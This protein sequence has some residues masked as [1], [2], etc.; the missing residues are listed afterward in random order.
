MLNP[1]KDIF[2]NIKVFS[3]GDGNTAVGIDIGSSA[4][5]V[6][7]I[8]KK[9]GKAMLETYGA[10][11]LGPYAELP[12]GE[13]TNLPVEKLAQ[14]VKEVLKQSGAV[15]DKA[16]IALPVQASLIF[17]IELPT[18]VKESEIAAIVPNEARRYIPV[19]ITEVSLD[20][21]MLPKK[22][23]SFE[24]MSSGE[25]IQ[26][27]AEKN[28]VL[29]VATQNDV[30]AKYRSIASQAGIK[31][32]FFEIEIFSSIRS[33]FE[34]ELS[35]VLLM[36]FGASRTKLS[37]V[38][39]GMVK[40]YHTIDRG[41][42]DITRSIATSLGVSFAQAEKMKKETGLFASSD[43]N[44]IG[45]IV[46]THIDYIFSEANNV[47]LGHEKKY[48]K[49]ITKVILSG[50]GSLLKGLEQAASSNFRAE[51]EFGRPFSKVG[52]PEFLNK[53]LAAT[54]P[55]FA[56]ALGIALRKLQ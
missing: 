50:G 29:V 53:V 10:I 36:D 47:L 44:N 52:A 16:E 43:E 51:V 2:S 3:G 35:L 39:F 14:S 54:G 11:A 12:A 13:V 21:F 28:R 4:I 49:A 30:I 42:V 56:V 7:E 18:Q 34:H 5:K 38:E 25:L 45:E 9:G 41:S 26:S 1:F 46:K 27:G 48:G 55:E 15:E 32:D 24:E 23:A 33:N 22:E 19:P 8:K 6:V 37:L 31:N 20:Y 40:G 17:T